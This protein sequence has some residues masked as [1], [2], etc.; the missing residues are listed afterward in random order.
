MAP[1]IHFAA[2][3]FVLT[4]ICTNSMAFDVVD[5]H[6]R[7]FQDT[8]FSIGAI[9]RTNP[10]SNL[11]PAGMTSEIAST[12]P[13]CSPDIK[14]GYMLGG[15]LLRHRV[16]GSCHRHLRGLRCRDSILFF[17]L[18][19]PPDA[20][21][22]RSTATIV[23]EQFPCRVR[24]SGKGFARPDRQWRVVAAKV[25]DHF[26]D[27]R[28]RRGPPRSG[29]IVTK[30]RLPLSAVSIG[31]AR[32]AA[33]G[34][35]FMRWARCTVVLAYGPQT[36]RGHQGDMWPGSKVANQSVR[37]SS[38]VPQLDGHRQRDHRADRFPAYQGETQTLVRCFRHFLPETRAPS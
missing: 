25:R 4:I 12:R 3:D 34:V 33:S 37:A 14:P 31:L 16:W 22:V 32:G 23:S 7:A 1:G 9:D 8:Q 18:F 2:A 10:A 35:P 20:N 26:H 19:L 11:I 21:G 36:S 15:K 17:L 24:C 28:R 13:T 30:G 5:A 6:W 38:P 29:R 27:L